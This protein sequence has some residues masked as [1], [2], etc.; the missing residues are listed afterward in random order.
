MRVVT[1]GPEKSQLTPPFQRPSPHCQLRAL[2]PGAAPS[3]H[4]QIWL[5]QTRQAGL[6]HSDSEAHL[7][8]PAPPGPSQAHRPAHRQHVIELFECR[9]PTVPELKAE[10]DNTVAGLQLGWPKYHGGLDAWGGSAI[11]HGE[12]RVERGRGP[13]RNRKKTCLWWVS[14]LRR[15]V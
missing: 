4:A 14:S 5:L 12:G 6:R 9:L 11:Q 8:Q 15:K 13:G 7:G 10:H 2:P 1:T 3:A